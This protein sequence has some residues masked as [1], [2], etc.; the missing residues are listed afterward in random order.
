MKDYKKLVVWEK[1]H[2][3]VLELYK[4]TK[5]FPVEERFNL[6]NQ[7]R[8]SG[9]SIPTNIAEGCGKFT[10]SDFVSYLQIALGST[11]ETEYLCFLSYELNYI[12]KTSYEKID[13]EI[14]EVKAMLISLIKKIRK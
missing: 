2:K 3:I 1:S 10:Q 13:R 12:D 7:F 6:V 11:Q 9:I 4:L 5:S 14:G 8:R